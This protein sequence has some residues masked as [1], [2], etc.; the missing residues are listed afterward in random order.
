MQDDVLLKLGINPGP[1]AVTPQGK[2]GREWP[3]LWRA[4]VQAL[5]VNGFT[6]EGINAALDVNI[7]RATIYGWA[8]EGSWYAAREKYQASVANRAI[9]RAEE[10]AVDTTERHIK[11]LR[12]TQAALLRGIAN[13]DTPVKSI[14]AAT[15]AL[16]ASI[17]AERQ[18]RGLAGAADVTIA[19]ENGGPVFDLES[20]DKLDPDS[21]R[22]AFAL[23]QK[24][25]EIE[26]ELNALASGETT[27]IEG[28]LVDDEQDNPPFEALE[29]SGDGSPSEVSEVWDNDEGGVPGR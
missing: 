16:V 26:N 15:A 11:S 29:G 17:K 6:P 1:L 23:Y 7:D 4:A 19:N 20:L 25:M 10:S 8:N 28:S 9:Q 18:I 12:A 21:R 5:F 2:A 13:K 14:E 27:V 22:R 24:K 3:P